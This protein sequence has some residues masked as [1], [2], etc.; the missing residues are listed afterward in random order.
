VCR[1]WVA[2]LLTAKSRGRL[3]ACHA[4]RL[5]PSHVLPLW[6][7]RGVVAG[8]GRHPV[9]V[10]LLAGQKAAVDDQFGPGDKR[11]FVG[12]QKQHAVGHFQGL[13]ETAQGR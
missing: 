5:H 4:C 3:P 8:S 12:G 11:R 2:R 10:G 13:P 6:I 7:R 9:W 1:Q